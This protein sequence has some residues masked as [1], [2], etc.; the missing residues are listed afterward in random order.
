MDDAAHVHG[1]GADAH[2]AAPVRWSPMLAG[3]PARLMLAGC[4]TIL[5]WCVVAW[6]FRS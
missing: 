1:H 2:P 4:L 3:L 5:L 6:S